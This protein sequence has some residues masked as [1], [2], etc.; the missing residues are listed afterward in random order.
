[1][2]GQQERLPVAVSLMGASGLDY[3]L[4]TLTRRFL[5]KSDLPKAV[6][7]GREMFGPDPTK[8]DLSPD[9]PIYACN[10]PDSVKI[11]G[12]PCSRGLDCTDC[13]TIR[14]LS[15]IRLNSKNMVLN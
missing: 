5:E 2:S 1:M 8:R 7:T 15:L 10:R 9:P 4:L 11:A 13:T 3:E 12:N 6:E 14:G